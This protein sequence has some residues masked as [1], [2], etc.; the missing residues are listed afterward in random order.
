MNSM[1][2]YDDDAMIVNEKIYK[3]LLKEYE[4]K[5]EGYENQKYENHEW[6]DLHFVDLD[7]DEV[8]KDFIGKKWIVVVDYHS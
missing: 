4:G 3:N 7:Y 6:K 2:G 5:S 1:K 8:S